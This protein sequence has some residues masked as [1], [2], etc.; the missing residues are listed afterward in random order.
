MTTA[1]ILKNAAL[2]T[3]LTLVTA[4]CNIY[5]K[6]ETPTDTALTQAYVEARQ[7]G[8]D[9]TAF[10]NLQWEQVFTDPVLTDYINRALANNISL[11]D[12]QLNVDLARTRLKGAKLAYFPSLALTP[13]GAG[14]SYAGNS[15]SWSYQIPAAISW[16]V[17]IFA[18][19]LN[20][21]RGAQVAVEQTEAYAQAVRSQIIAAVASTYYAI[22][23]VESQLALSRNT[24]RLWSQTVDNMNTMMQAGRT[25]KA[26]VVQSDANYRSV[27][28]SITD[29]EVT[30]HE[31]NNTMSQLLGTMPQEWHVSADATLEVPQMFVA[32][33]PMQYLANRPDVYAAERGLAT[34]YYA[35]NSA[36]AAFYPGLTISVNGGF[37]NLLGSFIKNPGDWFVQLAGSLVAPIFSRGQNIT[38]LQAARIGQQQ[39]MNSFEN[40]VLSAAGEVSDALTRYTKAGE[41]AGHLEQQVADLEKSVEYTNDIFTYANGIYL[42]VL[43]AQQQLLSAQMNLLVCRLTRAQA[44][45]SL[46]QAMGGGR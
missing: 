37:T 6:Y 42:E 41:R 40:T 14:A 29:L 8:V 32:G 13:N 45:I 31:L 5:K 35:T 24:A 21:K 2:L 4:S 17:D 44:V 3:T 39:A 22:A 1:K 46:Y 7:Q 20:S 9:S 18:K 36:R 33:V 34:A 12:A 19:L 25:N 16:E 10:G 27:L 15:M 38:N 30:R 11:K 23:S 26:A 28:A 43:T